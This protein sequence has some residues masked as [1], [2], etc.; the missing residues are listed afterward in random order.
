[1]KQENGDCWCNSR[2]GKEQAEMEAGDWLR[3]PLKEIAE[4][5]RAV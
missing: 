4:S 1:M 3:G 2:G 5:R